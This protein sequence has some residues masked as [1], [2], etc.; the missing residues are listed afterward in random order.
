VTTGNARRSDYRQTQIKYRAE[1][2][3]TAELVRRVLF[4]RALMMPTSAQTG[5]VEVILG[6]DYNQL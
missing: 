1:D 2:Q 4:R 5:G 3:K 6:S